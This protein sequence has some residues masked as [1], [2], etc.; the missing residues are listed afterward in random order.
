MDLSSPTKDQTPA[1]SS[2]ISRVLTTEPPAKSL[3]IYL[4]LLECSFLYNVVLVS[5]IQQSDSV[6]QEH[7]CS[8][9]DSFL[10]YV[11]TEHLVVFL[12]V[13]Y[14][15]CSSV[16]VCSSQASDSS[17]LLFVCVFILHFIYLF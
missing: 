17:L 4:I 12:W 14:L 11:I 15:M 9:L 8:F 6:P 5:G 10:I 13:I 1:P 16:H 2:E 3:F 7:I